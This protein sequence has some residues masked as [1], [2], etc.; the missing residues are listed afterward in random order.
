MLKALAWVG[1]G[2]SR[3]EVQRFP[4][5]ARQ[6]AGYELHLVQAGLQPSDWKPVTSIGPGVRE[7]RV[8]T[9][10]EH[11]VFYVATFEE[12]I[13]VLHAFEKKSQKTRSTI[14]K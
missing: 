6:R 9:G 5:N 3:G 7:I 14:C 10:M 1:P 8:H 4:S 13:Y 11:R 12:A 2:P